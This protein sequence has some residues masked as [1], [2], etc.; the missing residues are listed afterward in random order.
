MLEVLLKDGEIIPMYQVI[1][2]IK[3]RSD[4]MIY[5]TFVQGVPYARPSDCY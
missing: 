2:N 3:K 5:D 1:M 4:L